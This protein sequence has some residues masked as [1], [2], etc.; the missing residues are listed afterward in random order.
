MG[1][2]DPFAALDKKITSLKDEMAKAIQ[3]RSLKAE[4]KMDL[5]WSI[6]HDLQQ[7]QGRVTEDLKS[8]KT[9]LDSECKST[10]YGSVIAPTPA[11]VTPGSYMQPGIPQG[12]PGFNMH[13][14]VY[15]AAHGLD[16]ALYTQHGPGFAN[17]A[18]ANVQQGFNFGGYGMQLIHLPAVHC[19]IP[20]QQ[21]LHGRGYG[22]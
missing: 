16:Q 13:Q 11:Y 9:Q 18:I 6:L 10:P 22:R 4:E 8:M 1:S 2:T 20:A 3:E 15:P 21:H 5:V 19:Q 14:P 7:S 12:N 17:L